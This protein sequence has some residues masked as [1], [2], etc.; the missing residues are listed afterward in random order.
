[1]TGERGAKYRIDVIRES[2]QKY[3][4]ELTT[5]SNRLNLLF[6]PKKYLTSIFMSESDITRSRGGSNKWIF[7]VSTKLGIA[8]ISNLDREDDQEGFQGSS[9]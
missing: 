8:M 5:F 6:A 2:G 1:M 3:A 4:E 7:D 9:L